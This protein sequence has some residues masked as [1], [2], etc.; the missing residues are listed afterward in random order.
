MRCVNNASWEDLS[1]APCSNATASTVLRCSCAV[2]PRPIIVTTRDFTLPREREVNGSE[3]A[4]A[5][6]K[7][8]IRLTSLG[9]SLSLSLSGLLISATSRSEISDARN[10][11]LTCRTLQAAVTP[12]L[13]K[14][15]MPTFT[16]IDDLT[17]FAH[18]LAPVYL[19]QVR[20]LAVEIKSHDSNR[21]NL[22]TTLKQLP[23]LQSVIVKR[24]GS[25]AS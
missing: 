7:H 10:F 23:A 17:T 5:L 20:N 14:E 4:K 18:S 11:I 9:S 24:S 19:S 12:I 21:D 22:Q 25:F 13:Y 1:L 6:S 2:A 15:I 3:V 16:Y 8:S